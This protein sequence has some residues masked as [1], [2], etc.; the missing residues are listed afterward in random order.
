MSTKA[1]ERARL[2]VSLAARN[3][4]TIDYLDDVVSAAIQKHIPVWC[5]DERI[6]GRLIVLWLQ[7]KRLRVPWWRRWLFW[8]RLWRETR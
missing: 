1:D 5:T 6:K 3:S 2:L 8:W 4:G 7:R